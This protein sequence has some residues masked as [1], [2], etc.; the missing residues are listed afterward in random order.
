MIE[1]RLFLREAEP[2]ADVI[3][4]CDDIQARANA[5]G[6]LEQSSNPPS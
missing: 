4:R 5:I 3:A 6:S 1:S 2:F